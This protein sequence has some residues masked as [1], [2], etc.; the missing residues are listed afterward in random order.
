MPVVNLEPAP[1]ALVRRNRNAL[2]GRRRVDERVRQR[3]Q[4]AAR[5]EHEPKSQRRHDEQ[6]DAGKEAEPPHCSASVTTSV[7]GRL[8]PYTSGSYISS[9]CVGITVNSPAAIA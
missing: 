3:P 5:R 9:A 1:V 8:L 7:P 6:R 4:R 2:T